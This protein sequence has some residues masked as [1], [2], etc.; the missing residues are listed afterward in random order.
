M[1]DEFSQ[2]GSADSQSAGAA[3]AAADEQPLE[4]EE[5][6]GGAAGEDPE[7]EALPGGRVVLVGAGPGDPGLL[8]LRGR[9]VLEQAQVVVYDRLVDTTLLGHCAPWCERIYVG[10]EPGRHSATQAEINR[11]L[12]ERAARGLD[13]VRLKGGDPFVFGRGGEEAAAL[14]VTGIPFEVVPGVSSAVAAP[15]CA[16][17][18]VTHR[19][20]AA[21][22]AVVTGHERPGRP[23]AGVDWS[24]FGRQ[25]D[26]LVILMGLGEVRAIAE[27]LVAAG[28]PVSTPVAAIAH[29]STPRQRTV[30]STL[31]GI[32][33][34]VA[35]AGLDNPTTLVVGEVVRLRAQLQWFERRPLYGRRIVVTRMREQA[36]ELVAGLRDLGAEPVEL[37]VLT[38]RE[39]PNPQDLEWCVTNIASFWWLC[40]TSAHAVGP[41]F[42][43][44]RDNGLDARALAGTRIACVGPAT[45]RA[46]AAYGITADVVPARA[47]AADL[48]EALRQE[49][50]A[51]QRV[52]FVRGEP[53]SDTLVTG[54]VRL[55]LEVRQTIVY[56]ALP[57]AEAAGA[58]TELLASGA[59]AVTFASS[60]AVGH[61][62]DATGE[63]GRQ[64]CAGSRVVCIGPITARAAEAFG[65]RVDAVAREASMAG[66]RRA[67]LGLWR[68]REGEGRDG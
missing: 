60:S 2:Q 46:V 24:Q 13:V 53:A 57:D 18:P 25:P 42:T 5:P 68:G 35:A 30:V 40:F 11:I 16:G 43:A 8:T 62:L 14:A 65:L 64:L 58:A 41:F 37:P 67:L 22:F 55:G 28:R 51:G 31:E 59:D 39:V 21:S 19:D 49:A 61:F 4:V 34:A 50:R 6:G 63:A 36:S 9:E 17:I 1:A 20:V 38:I 15:A 29:G 26:T 3:K 66:M 54:L 27:A 23:T 45:A 33:D 56:E 47:S 32:A 48:V 52:L 44:L 7:E 12:V 10:K